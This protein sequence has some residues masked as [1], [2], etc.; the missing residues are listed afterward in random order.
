[1]LQIFGIVS[2]MLTIICLVPYVI[3]IFKLKTKPERASWLIWSVLGFIAFFSQLAKGATDSLWLTGAQTF[4]VLVVFLLSLKYGVGG[5]MKRDIIALI[6]AGMGII[7]WLLTK[8]AA[9]ALFIVIAVDFAGSVLTMIKSYED[10][11]S[12]TLITWVLSG[13]SGVFG[14]LSV[15]GWNLILLSYPIYI[16]LINYFIAGAVILG[17]RKKINLQKVKTKL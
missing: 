4:V 11:G 2:A 14:A 8:E 16:W 13:T 9:V 1:M 3:D 5:L 15:G 6:V 12:E 10:P 7:L 17:K